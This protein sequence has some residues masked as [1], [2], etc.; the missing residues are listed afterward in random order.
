[1]SNRTA[2]LLVGL[3]LFFFASVYAVSCNY[4][5]NQ[6]A[7]CA[8]YPETP[9][10]IDY[11]CQA[12]ADPTL[13][14]TDPDGNNIYSGT[15]VSYQQR[16]YSGRFM[17]GSLP[18]ECMNINQFVPSCSGSGC[19]VREIICTNPSTGQ[20][21][22][23]TIACTAGCTNGACTA[24]CYDGVQNQG[25]S[26]V[27]CGAACPIYLC[28]VGK[29]CN[30]NADC[31]SN[32]CGTGNLCANPPVATCVDGIKN[33]TESDIDC[34]GPCP[35][36]A[37]GQACVTSVDCNSSICQNNVCQAPVPSPTCSDGIKN[38]VDIDVDCGRYCPSKCDV[39][40]YC[41]MSIDCNSNICTANKCQPAPVNPTCFDG[42][43]NGIEVDT[44]C[45][46]YCPNTCDLNKMC[47]VSIDCKSNNCVGGYCVYPSHCTDTYKTPNESDLDCG[48][49]CAPCFVGKKC[50]SNNDCQSNQCVEGFCAAN[51]T[52]L[53]GIKDINSTETDIDCGGICNAKCDLNKT[54]L[55]NIDC[56]SGLCVNNVCKTNNF[57]LPETVDTATLLYY[58]DQWAKTNRGEPADPTVTDIELLRVIDRWKTQLALP[59]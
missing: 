50:D 43:K 19:N 55:A 3:G 34:G 53:N 23:Q 45:G 26:D 4:T 32:Y 2:V 52:C 49:E 46:R 30:T 15:S 41:E 12:H 7:Q 56:N 21:D 47:E 51:N 36:C 14:C 38:G 20:F 28:A 44:D 8:P 29:H 35:T 42:I 1:M 48:N 10:C 57:V 40:K 17:I 59:A 9:Y 27:D 11:S 22:F 5:I 37:N 33:Q 25:E 39:N 16:D 18:D 13:Y 31:Y 24:T 6:D 54:C 58:I